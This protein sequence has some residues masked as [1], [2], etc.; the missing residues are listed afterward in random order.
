MLIRAFFMYKN[1]KTQISVFQKSIFFKD[2]LKSHYFCVAMFFKSSQ[3]VSRTLIL[4]LLLSHCLLLFIYTFPSAVNSSRVKSYSVFTS[5]MFFFFAAS[6]FQIQKKKLFL[7]SLG[8]FVYFK[9]LSRKCIEKQ[10]KMF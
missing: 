6:P 8:L 7:Y 4:L 9:Q 1:S 5:T 3:L 10:E 2:N